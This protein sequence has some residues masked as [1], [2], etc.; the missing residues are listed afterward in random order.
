MRQCPLEL[1][2]ATIGSTRLWHN[3]YGIRYQGSSENVPRSTETARTRFMFAPMPYFAT[4]SHGERYPRNPQCFYALAVAKNAPFHKT[5]MHE[6][7]FPARMSAVRCRTN[8]RDRQGGTSSSSHPRGAAAYDVMTCVSRHVALC[9]TRRIRFFCH[10]DHRHHSH[11]CCLLPGVSITRPRG[12]F[13]P[14]LPACTF[15]H[16]HTNPNQCPSHKTT[17]IG[18]PI[19]NAIR[20][21]SFVALADIVV[22]ALPVHVITPGKPVYRFAEGAIEGITIGASPSFSLDPALTLHQASAYSV[23]FRCAR[24]ALVMLPVLFPPPCGRRL[25]AL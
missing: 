18:A 25:H 13:L 23:G 4:T 24:P 10:V 16:P 6:I 22:Y 8:G 1:Q 20:P 12:F 7:L 14:V 5:P 3:D 2:T 11:V 17:K 9:E 15:P 21:N 19:P